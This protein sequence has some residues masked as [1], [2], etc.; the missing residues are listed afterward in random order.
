MAS[1]YRRKEYVISTDQSLL[2]ISFIHAFLTQ[3]YWASGVSIENVK[4]RIAHSLCFGLFDQSRQ[5]GFARVI[6]DHTTI[7]YLKDVF[8]DEKY[9]GRKLSLWLLD[10]ILRDPDLQSIS[11]WLLRTSDAH[12]L[13]NKF[14]FV[15][16]G[17]PENLLEYRLLR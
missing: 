13:Y 7:A 16:V 14:G 12:G 10:T 2:D 17:A 4:Q 1:E 5:I 6:T 9:R 3:S 8:I 11:C 15:P